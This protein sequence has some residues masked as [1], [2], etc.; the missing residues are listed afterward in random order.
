M[1]RLLYLT[2]TRPDITYAVHKLSQF[3]SA[4]TSIHLQAAHR[5]LQYLKN[6]PVQGLFYSAS[7]SMKL[8]AYS[9]ADW[10]AC[11]DSRL[12]F[13]GY[14]MFLGDSLISWSS[15]K[16]QTVSR[17]S[18]EAEYRGMADAT[19][20][21]IWLTNLLQEMHC[22]PSAPANLFCD[23]QSTLYIASNPVFHERTKHVENDY[24]II[25]ER[26]QS[27]FLRTRHVKTD[28]QLADI[29]TKAVQPQLFRS[30]LT[31]IRTHSLCI[32]S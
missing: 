7:S 8:T 14:C 17:S 6:D 15:K 27:G 24:R 19:C 9:D 30:L 26:L 28:L 29:F 23:N 4:P 11:P 22:P 32:P 21:L 3:M 2:H 12:S 10:D 20:E 25:R 31:K 18:S 13:T 1:G 5:V 16:Q